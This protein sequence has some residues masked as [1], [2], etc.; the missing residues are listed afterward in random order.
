MVVVFDIRPVLF[1]PHY[2]VKDINTEIRVNIAM[3]VAMDG[4]FAVSVVYNVK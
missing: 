2:N 3:V 4:W 1:G